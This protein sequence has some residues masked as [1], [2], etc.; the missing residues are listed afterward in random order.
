MILVKFVTCSIFVEKIIVGRV[1]IVFQMC[2]QGAENDK[3]C[4]THSSHGQL[5]W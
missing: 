1:L 5:A 4:S 3:V 2:L